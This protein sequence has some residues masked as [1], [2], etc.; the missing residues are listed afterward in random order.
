M[1]FDS[2]LYNA[3]LYIASCHIIY[4]LYRYPMQKMKQHEVTFKNDQCPP[5]EKE[6]WYKLQA[7]CFSLLFSVLLELQSFCRPPD[8]GL[9]ATVK[10]TLGAGS[11]DSGSSFDFLAEP[12]AFRIPES[13]TF[14]DCISRRCSSKFTAYI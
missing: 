4:K 14:N 9:P 12:M 7:L 10:L 5:K 11:W 13:S 8:S 2:Q 1:I 3:K 6:L